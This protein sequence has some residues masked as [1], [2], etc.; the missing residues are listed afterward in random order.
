MFIVGPISYFLIRLY[1]ARMLLVERQRRGLVSYQIPL[2]LHRAHRLQPVAP[3]H[4]FLFGHL[5]YL[6]SVIDTLPEK[7]HYQ[8]AF[9]EIA[10]HHFINE[11]VYYIDL[12]PVSGLFLIVVSPDVAVQATQV[13]SRLA[14]EKPS[15]L[16]RFFKPITG[17][18]SL[19]DMPE[20]EWKPWRTTFNKGFSPDHVL[21]LVPGM[22]KE[23]SVYCSTL[24]KLARQGDLVLLDPTT[25]RFTMDLIGQNVLSVDHS[26]AFRSYIC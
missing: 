10:R 14:I 26:P 5:L 15:L 7:C 8:Y 24:R 12:W 11:G 2:Q 17:G 21:S 1:H 22:A 20:R 19:F 18:P 4:R 3:G 25:L 9:R 16:R 13:N 23:T 6:K